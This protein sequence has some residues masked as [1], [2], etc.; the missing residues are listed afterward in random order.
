MW[1]Q[2]WLADLAASHLEP[3]FF[4]SSSG[5][6]I[7]AVPT[8]LAALMSPAPILRAA[9][10]IAAPIL[11]EPASV[12]KI[13]SAVEFPPTVKIA[14]V[15]F[16][17]FT[18]PASAI[19][20]MLMEFPKSPVMV[21]EPRIAED[22]SVAVMEAIHVPHAAEIIRTVIYRT[23]AV[24][25]VPGPGADEHAVHKPLRPVVAIRRATERIRRIKSP[26]ANRWRVVYAVIRANVDP[27][28]N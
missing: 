16:P 15:K 18:E 2:K 22:E 6:T 21:V 14:S 10:K 26:L 4:L 27:D 7:L 3:T 23:H 1:K 9:V 28:S 8:T 5:P 11:P 25:V 24:K 17:R 12:V 13:S 19:K 20:I